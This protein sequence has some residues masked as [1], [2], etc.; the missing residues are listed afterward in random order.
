M[1]RRF[2]AVALATSFCLTTGSCWP[3][4]PGADAESPAP[5][6]PPVEDARVY[7]HGL[8]DQLEDRIGNGDNV[9][10]WEGQAWA[11]TDQNRLWLKSEGLLGHGSKVSDGLHEAL[12]DRP[13]STFFDV[14]AGLRYDVDSDPSRAWAALGLQGLAPQWFNV[15]ATV[16]A[17]DGG[18]L[19]ARFR[20]SYELLFT[21]RLILEPEIEFNAYSKADPSRGVG[22]GLSELEGGFRLRYEV[23]RKFAPYIGLNDR[24]VFG[25]TA[26]Y[27]RQRGETTNDLSFVAGLRSW[28]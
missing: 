4:T 8:F 1:K 3:Q 9:L 11:G 17:S 12:Y 14:Q 13:F 23:S 27:A 18:H 15:E 26:G 20:T 7:V 22:A 16:Y 19:A 10:R 28:F 24:T 2:A 5:F 6:G 21:Q 25:S